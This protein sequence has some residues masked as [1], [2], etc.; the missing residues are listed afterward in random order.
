[1]AYYTNLSKNDILELANKYGI[2]LN[3]YQP[4]EQ[5]IS[6]SNFLLTTEQGKFVLTVF[7]LDPI[8][9]SHIANVLR[10][11]EQHKFPAP[12]LIS[13]KDGKP[14]TSFQDKPVLLKSYLPG[15]VLDKP[16]E[17]QLGQVG[18]ALAHLHE[19]PAP[20]DL[21]GTPAYITQTYPTV[22]K[23][24]IDREYR[25][26]IEKRCNLINK[27]FPRNLPNGLIHGDLFSDNIL[28]EDG[29]FKA[30][31]DFE[32]T[33]QYFKVYDL[34]MAITGNCLNG[35]SISFGRTRAL[36][37]G[38]KQVRELELAEKDVMQLVIEWAAILTSAWRYWK[39]NIDKLDSDNSKRYLE[40]VEIAQ[41]IISI[42]H[43]DF[44]HGVFD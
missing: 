13:T 10:Q 11:L 25:H 18:T 26:W 3:H 8:Q 42:P 23:A 32:D 5:G 7:E 21:P 28:F 34:G 27:N 31:L 39:F 35:T 24:E 43:H 41:K 12:R 37:N 30:M 19:I 14:I 16:D 6:N 4:I 40:M 44:Q 38:Y 29:K 17:Q 20:E 1:M 36:L 22:I 9:A 15:Q 2:K 33:C